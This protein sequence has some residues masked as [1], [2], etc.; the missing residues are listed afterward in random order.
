MVPPQAKVSSS[1]WGGERMDFY[2]TTGEMLAGSIV[3]GI[4]KDAHYKVDNFEGADKA[5]RIIN[6]HL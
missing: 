4:G 3:K 1:G 2:K 5:A 6:G